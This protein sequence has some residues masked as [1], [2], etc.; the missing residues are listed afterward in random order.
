[1][2]MSSEGREPGRDGAG[3]AQQQPLTTDTDFSS[4][5]SNHIN[6]PAVVRR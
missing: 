4:E 1:M 5:R 3:E 6:N 2:V